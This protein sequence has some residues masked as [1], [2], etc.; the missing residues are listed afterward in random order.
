MAERDE[1]VA[2]PAAHQPTK[3]ELEDDVGVDATPEAFAWA[4]KLGGTE[5]RD[6]DD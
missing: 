5:R 2:N 6:A 4:V 1:R 3:A